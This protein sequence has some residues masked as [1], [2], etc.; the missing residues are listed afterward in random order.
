VP[1]WF[2]AFSAVLLM[3]AV[4]GSAVAVVVRYRRSDTVTRQ[5]LKWVAW[6]GFLLAVTIVL[7]TPADLWS[8]FWS[9]VTDIASN[10]VISLFPVAVGVAV[11]RYRLFD[12]DRLLS[13]TVSYTLLSGLVGGLFAGVVLLAGL[14]GVGSSWGVAAATLLSLAVL[15][16]LRRR[17]QTLV[18]RRFDRAR[19]DGERTAEE[20]SLRLRHEVDLDTVSR[21]LLGTVT[22][23]L[24]P[25][26]ASVWLA[27]SGRGPHG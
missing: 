23:S 3:L 7:G 15:T 27:R 4:I 17:L 10:L 20:F 18:D 19:V 2:S 21:D 1:G 13:R 14:L 26:G 11:S 5:Q 8:P 9:S 16:P 22:R 24:A 25:A 12:I 6:V